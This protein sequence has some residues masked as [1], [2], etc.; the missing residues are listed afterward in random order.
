MCHGQVQRPPGWQGRLEACS[1][2]LVA[3]QLGELSYS[4]VMWS[5]S[6]AVQVTEVKRPSDSVDYVMYMSTE[7]S[8]DE[9][10]VKMA[11]FLTNDHPAIE[12]F[13]MLAEWSN[14][15]S[16]MARKILDYNVSLMGMRA[17][18][19]SKH[20]TPPYRYAK[21]LLG[22][23]YAGN[24]FRETLEVM[25]SDWAILTACETSSSI[26]QQLTE[27][28]LVTMDGPTRLMML[29]CESVKFTNMPDQAHKILQT[30]L[31]TLPDSKIIEDLHQKVRLAQKMT[32]AHEKMKV[33][34][35]QHLIN[36]SPVL[37]SRELNHPVKLSKEFFLDNIRGTK[38]DFQCR[39]K[40]YGRRHKLPRLYGQMLDPKKTWQSVTPVSLSRSSAA[41][42]WVREFRDQRLKNA[43]FQLK[44]GSVL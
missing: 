43:G 40:S 26:P 44:D 15:V 21:A 8:H 3:I 18:S 33:S 14:D 23:H 24:A 17:S 38:R 25:K 6:V 19:L 5:P 36:T 37:R 41:W 11:Q 13:H 7:W 16:R 12:V 30:M 1:Y 31:V 20:T 42:A 10:F 39:V 27:D 4:A 29:F 2:G 35:I 32:S 9:Q 28:L 34:S 22:P